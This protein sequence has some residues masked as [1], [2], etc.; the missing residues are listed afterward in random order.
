MLNSTKIWLCTLLLFLGGKSIAQTILNGD[1]EINTAGA[2]QINMTNAAFTAAMS[3]AVAFGTTPNMDIITTNQYCGFP[4]SGN[5]HVAFTTGGTDAISLELS[6]PLTIGNSY[7]ITYYDR[8]CS[9]WSTAPSTI[10]VSTANNAMGTIVYTSPAVPQTGIWNQRTFTFVAPIAATF[11]TISAAGAP[12]TS[13]WIQVDNIAFDCAMNVDLGNDTLLCAGNNLLLDA[14]NP[15]S[16]YLWQDGSTNATF[17]V[18]TAGTYYV[19]VTGACGTATDTIVVTTGTPPTVDLGNDT[20]IC[21]GTPLV[22]DATY[23]ASTYLWQDGSTNATFNTSAAGTYYVDVTNNCG[24]ATDTI[25][26]TSGGLPV[27]DLGNDTLICAGAALLLDATNPNSTYLWQDGSTNATFNATTANTYYVDVTNNCG[28]ATDTIVI[29]NGFPPT[30]NLGNDTTICVNSPLVLDATSPLSTYLW[31]DGSTNATFTASS[32]NTYYVDVTNACGTATDTINIATE[33]LPVVDLGNDTILCSGASLTLDATYPNSTYL[34]QDG[35]TNTTLNA[36]ATNTY[37]VDV[38]NNC[39]TATDTIDILSDVPPTVDLGNDTTICP[40]LPLILDATNP[41]S[42]YLWQ[43]GTTDPTLTVSSANTYYVDVTNA[44]GTATDTIVIATETFPVVDLG[45]DTT[46]CAGA[47]LT[48]DATNPNSTYLWQDGTTD[49]TLSVSTANT[50]FVDVT[51]TCGTVTDT[52]IVSYET[53]PTID[54]GN[55]TTLCANTTY[56]LDA[57]TPDVSYLWQDNS[58]SPTY[59]VSQQG[60][61]WVTLTNNCGTATDSIDVNY[62]GAIAFDLGND[63][64][65]CEGSTLT[66]DVTIPNSTVEWQDQST[67][68][69]YIVTGFGIYSATVNVGGCLAYDTIFVDAEELPNADLGHDMLLCE[70]DSMVLSTLN[71]NGSHH[72]NTGSSESAI[73][74]TEFGDYWLDVTNVCGTVSDTITIGDMQCSCVMYFPNTF[75]PDGDEFNQNFHAKYE[76]DI[77]TYN[78]RIYNRWGQLLFT[79]DNPDAIWDGTY[80]GKLVPTGT[81]VY[82]VEYENDY[83][84]VERINGHVNVLY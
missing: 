30:V 41:L 36:A 29:L 19:D 82:L 34:W 63:T 74:V 14:T 40:N 57:T 26:V 28:T 38:T 11:I 43:D 22:L 61:Y 79:T 39:G 9:T 13:S 59:T 83:G 51:S 6:A 46:L 66:L 3:N 2:N 77:Y 80:N 48:L 27:V 81:Y 20:A 76:C 15:A 69:S 84:I 42:T 62:N 53:A 49:P 68:S 16:T 12:S 24:T 70:G 72:W 44:C 58:T 45:N 54:L 67:G 4:Q 50:Y 75:T 65:V 1:F 25:V 55:D 5:W 18:S 17:N 8:G 21:V 47:T 31:Q 33:T 52:I 32:A 35:S 73:L 7:T 71:P 60:T 23:P 78:L 64:V 37:Y 10:G 56:L